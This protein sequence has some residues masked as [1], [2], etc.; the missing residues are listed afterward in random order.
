MIA[1]FDCFSGISGDMTLGAL[2]DL[3][4]PVNY[5][6]ETLAGL[7]LEG[8]D[9][10]VSEIKRNGI[11]AKNV[12][13]KDLENRHSRNYSDIKSLISDSRLSDPVKK[14]SLEIFHKIAVAESG[15]HGNPI[16]KVHFHEVGGID[17]IVDIVGSVLALEY[18][19]IDSV[20][21]SKIPVGQG[22]V[23]CSHGKIPV[24]SPATLSILKGIPVY[25]S[26]I[27]KELVT[28]TGAAIIKTISES[29]SQMPEMIVEKI[30][31]GSGKRDLKEIPN[32][33][34]VVVGER[35]GSRTDDIIILETS[36]DDMNPEIFGFVMERLFKDGALDVCWIPVFMKKN[37]PGTQIQVICK[38]GKKDRLTDIILSETT[39]TGVRYYSAK[40]KILERETLEVE[41][42]YGKIQ[43][44]RI[45]NPDGSDRLVPEYEVCKN[46]A[47]EREIPLK[48]VYDNLCREL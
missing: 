12:F 31:Y 35:K 46:I 17:A 6:K 16:E 43:V 13:V 36:I 7:P 37:R 26:G 3:G 10:A 9:I 25:G 30:G 33:L 45:V 15:I 34:R 5:L 40:R 27:E 41:T 4:V 2:V 38:E 39:S 21:S 14:Q 22:F 19:G 32:L 23:K 8:F 11:T 28:P 47:E 1:Y 18:L 29:F 48:I 24:P 20:F 42:A 44:K